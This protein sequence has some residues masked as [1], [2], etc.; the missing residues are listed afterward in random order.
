VVV[1]CGEAGIAAVPPM[2]KKG[3]NNNKGLKQMKK[4]P[5]EAELAHRRELIQN[6]DIAKISP[7]DKASRIINGTATPANLFPFIVGLQTSFFGPPD[8]SFDTYYC[9]GTLIDP[10]WVLTAASCID[11]Y[12]GSTYW[13]FAGSHELSANVSFN[14]ISNPNGYF[15]EIEKTVT[16]PDFYHTTDYDIYNFTSVWINDVALVKLATPLTWIPTVPPTSIVKDG[17]DDA[18]TSNDPPGGSVCIIAAF[19]ADEPGN[20]WPSGFPHELLQADMEV[21][22]WGDATFIL[23]YIGSDL[24]LSPA[25]LVIIGEP[26]SACNFDNGGP[27]LCLDTTGNW[28]QAGIISLAPNECDIAPTITTRVSAIEGW[29]NWVIESDRNPEVVTDTVI[30]FNFADLYT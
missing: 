13:V 20:N 30:N 26:Q 8:N 14:E 3:N 18:F 23:E 22:S 21:L 16:H 1:V 15:W 5:T 12:P 27:V 19:G 9:T 17:A 6:I 25:Q 28:F 10:W 4:E 7:R 24:Q 11:P 29:V 2:L